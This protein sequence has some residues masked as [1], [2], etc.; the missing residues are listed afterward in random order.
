MDVGD[1]L[2]GCGLV[3][4]LRYLVLLICCL[5][6]MFGCWVI[7]CGL[8]VWWCSVYVLAGYVGFGSIVGCALIWLLC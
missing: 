5:W 8:W 6:G 1:L 3:V 4:G 7:T 2:V